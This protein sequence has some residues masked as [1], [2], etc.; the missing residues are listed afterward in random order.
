MLKRILRSAWVQYT[1]GLI[2]AGYMSLIKNTTR[3]TV[4]GREV[5]EPIWEGRQG[6]IGCVWH[7]RTLMTIA[8]WP[9][10][11]Q[12]AAML[13]SWSPDG[14]FTNR[15]ALT[16]GIGVIRGG[17]RNPKKKGKDAQKGAIGAFRK[18]AAWIEAGGCMALTP[19]G[20]RGPRMRAADGPVR[21]SRA[22]GAPMMAF[23]WSTTSRVMV[24]SWDRLILPLP[25]SRGVIVWKGPIYAPQTDD[26]AVLEETRLALEK[27]LNDATREADQACG[28]QEVLPEPPRP[29][30]GG[31]PSGA[32]SP[33]EAPSADTPSAESLA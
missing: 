9:K 25:F 26:K 4:V 29:T 19:D 10:G 16:H 5:I 7:G 13:V 32:E 23:S 22:T 14:E 28:H 18:M 33:E 24:E 8:G 12:P 17:A 21:L 1:L 27:A 31:E 20:P 3:W 15:A 11:V 2:L 6:V 30:R